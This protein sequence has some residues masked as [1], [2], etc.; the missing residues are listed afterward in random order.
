MSN[1][2]PRDAAALNDLLAAALSLADELD[3]PLVAIR[4]DEARSLMIDT[5][6][7]PD[8]TGSDRATSTQNA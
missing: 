7:W 8:I 5:N 2:P 4:I 3:L 6:A 1:V